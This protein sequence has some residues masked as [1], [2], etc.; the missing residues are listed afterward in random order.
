M[1]KNTIVLCAIIIGVIFI[2]GCDNSDSPPLSK[3]EANVMISEVSLAVN[4]EA[5]QAMADAMSKSK[6]L[7]EYE[8]N[9]TNET[10]T[11]VITG[12][13]TCDDTDYYPVHYNMEVLFINYVPELSGNVT[14]IDGSTTTTLD[15]ESATNLSYSF[16]GD[17]TVVYKG[18]EY[19]CSWSCEMT[20]NDDDI[21]YSGSYTVDGY[22]YSYTYGT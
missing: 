21:D 2:T 12:A 14:L 8:I 22:T 9:Y 18:E 20:I 4:A 19:E 15:Q 16:S 6:V 3:K 13:I 5:G 1:R 17:F 11:V 7:E 10:G